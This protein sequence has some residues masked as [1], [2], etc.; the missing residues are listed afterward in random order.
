[1]DELSIENTESY[2][3]SK[4]PDV[5]SKK[6][7]K[8][9]V[10][11]RGRYFRQI[12]STSRHIKR[13]WHNR[14]FQIRFPSYSFWRGWVRKLDSQ[15]L[16]NFAPP[17][18]R[19]VGKSYFL[20]LC[21]CCTFENSFKS[22][23]LFLF[24]K[25]ETYQKVVALVFFSLS[26]LLSQTPKGKHLTQEVHKSDVL[27]L[28]AFV[29]VKVRQSTYKVLALLAKYLLALLASSELQDVLLP[30]RC[31]ETFWVLTNMR[32]FCFPLE[33]KLKVWQVDFGT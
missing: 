25:N 7:N 31:G 14:T 29:K 17:T 28:F 2:K 6:R 12:L 24:H 27:L 20:Y 5:N 26:M 19:G 11:G 8:G 4:H 18:L 10:R 21:V 23:S 16:E 15:S 30:V 9:H 33:E 32:L 1:M 13:F 22:A 3:A